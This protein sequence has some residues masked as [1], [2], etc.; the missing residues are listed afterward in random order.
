MLLGDQ[1]RRDDVGGARA[2]YAY[3]I[4]LENFGRNPS[5]EEPLGRP[6]SRWEDKINMHLKRITY[7][8]LDWIGYSSEFL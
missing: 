1:I 3:G 7:E 4:C 2:S 5:R 8:D 6:R